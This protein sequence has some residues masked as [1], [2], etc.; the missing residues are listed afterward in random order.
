MAMA[1]MEVIEMTNRAGRRPADAG[2]HDR[3]VT[4]GRAVGG[5]QLAGDWPST[6]LLGRL[7]DFGPMGA[8]QPGAPAPMGD[9]AVVDTEHA[10]GRLPSRYRKAVVDFYASAIRLNT[11]LCARRARCSNRQFQDMLKHARIM[12]SDDFSRRG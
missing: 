1:A 8:G 2:I 11:S 10:V 9:P 7:I 5:R 4:W 6:T 3:L 12:L